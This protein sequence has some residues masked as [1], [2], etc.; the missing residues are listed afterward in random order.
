MFAESGL[1]LCQ[2]GIEVFRFSVNSLLTQLPNAFFEGTWTLGI[3]FSVWNSRQYN[4]RCRFSYKQ[5]LLE[6]YHQRDFLPT[7]TRACSP[8][9][10]EN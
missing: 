9:T 6:G 3:R 7:V 8:Q 1:Q 4:G 5:D 10:I 2:H